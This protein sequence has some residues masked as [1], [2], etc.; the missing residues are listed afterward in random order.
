MHGPEEA[1][2]AGEILP[3]LKTCSACLALLL[4][5]GI[6][7][8]ERHHGEPERMHPR[9]KDRVV[10]I[11]TGFLDRTGDELHLYVRGRLCA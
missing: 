9:G 2:F 11:N 8:E 5:V 1:A 3:A 6:M 10:F 7:D 4:K